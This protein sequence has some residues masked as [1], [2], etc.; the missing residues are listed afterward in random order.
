MLFLLLILFVIWIVATWPLKKIDG[1]LETFAPLSLTTPGGVIKSTLGKHPTIKF[2]R[3]DKQVTKI[4]K[5]IFDQFK[6]VDNDSWDIYVP[7]GY[8]YVEKELDENSHFVDRKQK[9]WVLGIQGSDNFAAKDRAWNLLAKRY[10]RLRATIYMPESWVTYEPLQ[11]SAFV[12]YAKE[13]PTDMYIMKKNIQQQK[14]LKIIHSANEAQN[15]F[16]DSYV[17]VQ[18]ILKDPYLVNGRKINIRVYILVVCKGGKKNLFVYDDGFVYYSKVPYKTGESWDEIVTSGYI[19]RNVYDENPLTI[20]D[21]LKYIHEHN[22]AAAVDKFIKN[23]NY[24]LAGFLDAVKDDFCTVST[25]NVVN[26]QSYGVDMQP[27]K[28]LTDVKILEIN[29]G[30][31]LEIMDQRDGSLKQKMMDDMFRTI[32]VTKDSIPSGYSKIWEG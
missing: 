2:K 6:K 26:A 20:K 28:D 19:S 7:C 27:N 14:G 1:R 21:L 17:V 25:D 23:R 30:Q 18:R 3:C 9:G 22:G 32:G 4:E 16:K 29:K 5:N 13:H 31:S 11:M 24:I 10:G 12:K 8:T 15:A